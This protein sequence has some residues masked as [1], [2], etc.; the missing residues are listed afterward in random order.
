MFPFRHLRSRFFRPAI[1]LTLLVV[2]AIAMIGYPISAPSLEKSGRFPCEDCSCGCATADFCWD[3]CCCH[4][5]SEKLQWATDHGVPPP[6][7]LVA[8]VRLASGMTM[9]DGVDPLSKPSASC[10]SCSNASAR[11]ATCEEPQ[12]ISAERSDGDINRTRLVRL[13]DAAKCHGIDWLWSLFSSVVVDVRR[14]LILAAEPMLL[15]CLRTSDQS[16]I[17]MNLCPDP[18]IP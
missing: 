13:E 8:R 3:K 10:C 17:P 2:L 11:S 9:A 1:S 15:F 14:P 5:D 12:S 6:L 4:S 18:P 7:F 16:P